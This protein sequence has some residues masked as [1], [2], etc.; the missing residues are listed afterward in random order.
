MRLHRSVGAVLAALLL[1]VLVAA[2]A[3]ATS[4]GIRITEPALVTQT[5]SFRFSEPLGVQI[6]CN[7]TL[8]KTLITETL[9]KVRP[10]LVKLGRV[11]AGRLAPECPATFLNLPARLTLGEPGPN[12]ESWDLAYLSSNLPGGELNFGI[13][14][15][16]VQI[17]Y[18]LTICLYRGVLLG[19]LRNA[20]TLLRYTGRMLPLFGGIGCPGVLNVEGMFLNAPPITYV[21]LP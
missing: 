21:L 15:F 18:G 10:E 19:T 4:T 9:I 14:D 3:S 17:T 7:A 20:G 1:T 8:S 16:Q 11:G 12:P 2:S 5:G 13:L 6:V